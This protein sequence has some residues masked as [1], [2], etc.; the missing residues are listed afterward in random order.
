MKPSVL[1]VGAGLGGCFLADALAESWRVT[2]VELGTTQLQLQQRIVDTDRPAITRPHVGAGLGGST[3]V[4]HN[5]LI[6]IDEQTF[7]DKWPFAKAELL[8]YYARAFPVLAGVSSECAQQATKDLR[9]KLVDNGLPPDKLRDGLYYPR[10]RLNVWQALKL[11]GR[12]ELVRGEV[13]D[14]IP[15]KA[16]QIDSVVVSTAAGA[17]RLTADVVVVAAGGLATPLLL[18]RL[19]K[20]LPLPAL[21]HAGC[22]YEDHPCGFIGDVMFDQPIHKLWNY[23]V[24]GGNGSLRLPMVVREDG[25]LVSFQLRPAVQFRPRKRVVS[26][27]NDLRNKPFDPRNYYRLLFLWDDVLEILS[28]R[29]GIHLPTRQYSLLM[30]AQQPPSIGRA[31]WQDD[32]GGA[33]YRRWTMPTDYLST[34]NAAI[35]Q[36]LGTMKDKIRNVSLFDNWVDDLYSSSHHSGTARMADSPGAGV[37]NRDGRVH[38]IPN[39][40]VCDGSL[41]PGSGCANTGLTIAALAL[42]LADHLKQSR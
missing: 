15:G 1:I 31:V 32:P 23:S 21:D 29:F 33:I 6:E 9:Q 35:A 28:F 41:I 18:Q 14:L 7:R 34:L 26:V 16:G 12:V 3:T 17:E 10:H 38:G 36:V 19:A 4:W 39:L 5:G 42:R 13:S 20:L 37:C 11:K 27:L 8:P 2:V 22:H 30:I 24:A 25:L 40:Y